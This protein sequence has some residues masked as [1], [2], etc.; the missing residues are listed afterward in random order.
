MASKTHLHRRSALPAAPVMLAFILTALAPFA[1]ALAQQEIS[2]FAF[3]HEDASMTV[4]GQ[5]VRLFGIYVPPTDR[6]CNTFIRP[7]PCGTRASLAL[8][9]KV[10]GDF[11]RCQPRSRNADGS[12]NASCKAGN[13]DL[14]EWMLQRGWAV[15]L[16]DAPFHYAALEKIAR[17]KGI[18]IWGIAIDR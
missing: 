7:I 13:D 2:S 10:S 16:P 4:G 14:S 8:E 3:V 12:I 5:R 11:V 9:F 6:T 17:S 18:G 1:D 15:A